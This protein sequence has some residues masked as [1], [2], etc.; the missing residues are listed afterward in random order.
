MFWINFRIW[1]VE[2]SL[3]VSHW[4][5]N[6]VGS[7]CISALSVINSGTPS[8][9]VATACDDGSVRIWKDVYQSSHQ[10]TRDPPILVTA[11][12]ATLDINPATRG[13]ATYY[14]IFLHKKVIHNLCIDVA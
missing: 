8:T 6:N 9:Y 7:S 4:S 10:A 14:L 2:R 13:M 12:Q 5:N 1:D 3:R 11:F